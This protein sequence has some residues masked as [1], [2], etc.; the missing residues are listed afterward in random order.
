MSINISDIKTAQ[1]S[2][3]KYW[4]GLLSRMEFFLKEETPV[5]V[6]EIFAL[7]A[8]GD[9]YVERTACVNALAGSYPIFARYWASSHLSS[10]LNYMWT[11]DFEAAWSKGKEKEANKVADDKR[12]ARRKELQQRYP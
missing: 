3:K 2:S 4:D 8:Y 1:D 6:E 9:P 12:N 11:K 7:P 5:N 10:H